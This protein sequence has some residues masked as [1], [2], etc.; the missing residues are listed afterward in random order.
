MDKYPMDRIRNV[1]LFGH[2]HSGKTSLAEAMLFNAGVINRMGTVSEGNTQSDYDADEHKRQISINTVPLPFDWNNH[3]VNMIDTP[4]FADFMGEVVGAL[5]AIDG[6]VFVLSAVSGVE[7]QTELIW[8]KADEASLP[9]LVF[10]NKMD[11]E[12]ASFGRCLDQ[13]TGLYG[14]RVVALQLP[15]GEENSF[16]GIVDLV[17]DRALTFDASG[18]ISEEP[19]PADM[20]DAVASAREKLLEGV[21]ESND[22]LLERYLE[23]ESLDPSEVNAALLDSISNGSLIPLLCGSATHNIG[24]PPLLDAIVTGL[25]SPLIKAEV[26]GTKPGTETEI[27]FA[28]TDEAP[29]AALVFKTVSDPY[30]GKLTYFRVFSGK[31]K[32]DSAVFNPA[33]E[34]EE[35]IGQVFVIR[36]KTQEPAREITA[37]DIGG[38]AKL[39]ETATGDTLCERGNP[40]LLEPIQFPKPV[41]SLAV[42]P[43]SK[44]D[45]DKL[46]SALQR[47]VDEDPSFNVRR[48]AGLKQT[49]ISGLGEAHLDSILDRMARKFGVEVV[50]SQPRIPYLESIRKTSRAEGKHKKQTGGHGQFGV[51]FV[52]LEPLERGAGFEFVDK[53]V[54]GAIPRQFIPAVEKG[55]REG[56]DDGFLSGNPITDIRATVYDGKFHPV[57]SSEMSFKIAGSL[58]LKGALEGAQPYIL[59]PIAEAEI[60]VP[61]AFM[62]DVIGDLNAKRGRIMGMEPRGGLQAIKAQ[63]P[64]AE[65]ARYSIDLRSITGGRGTFTM[66]FSHYEEAPSN[67]AEKIIAAARQEKE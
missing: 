53:I 14:S 22:A 31:L 41:F 50:T 25:P 65:M 39:T 33:Q 35:R 5:R 59:E 28:A 11:R 9:R 18:K 15:I 54:G 47:L 3:K 56:M 30:V 27:A 37:G 2:G 12:N 57:D 42:A 24:I 20:E 38:V 46:G 21:A 64:V 1:A 8:Q 44:G 13:L 55:L 66:D 26:A 36:G 45:E 63:V 60:L 16:R 34:K 52:E 29:L 17:G 61:E 7:V 48:D 67:V 23:G 51:A 19:I 32:A 49:I 62:G 43:K 58:A 6:A 4:G 10:I 40:M